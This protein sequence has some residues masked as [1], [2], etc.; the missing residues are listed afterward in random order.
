MPIGSVTHQVDGIPFRGSFEKSAV[1]AVEQPCPPHKA[2]GSRVGS[3]RHM[4]LPTPKTTFASS[5]KIN[6][7]LGKLQRYRSIKVKLRH[8]R[9]ALWTV[10]GSWQCD[11]SRR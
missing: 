1:E 2:R 10:D 9:H 4:I 3:G 6:S 7:P 11:R 5:E 8:R